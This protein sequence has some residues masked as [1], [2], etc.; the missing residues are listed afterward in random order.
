MSNY[1]PVGVTV[2]THNRTDLLAA[3]LESIVAQDY[4]GPVEIVVVHDKSTPAEFHEELYSRLGVRWVPNTCTSGLAGARN[5]GVAALPTDLVAFCDDDDTWHPSKLRNQIDEWNRSPEANLMAT[6]SEI[7][8]KGR[9]VPRLTPRRWITHKAL[10]RNRMATMAS[11]SFL[12][13]KEF[14]LSIG[15][16]GEGA[17]RGQ[18]EDWDL[19]LRASRHG[20]VLNVNVPLVRVMWDRDSYFTTH[21]ESKIAGLRWILDEHPDIWDDRVAL[22]RVLG[23][24]AYW[25]ASSSE[26]D[27][28]E[29]I[30]RTML[31]N[32]TQWRAF[33]ALLVEARVITS[34]QFLG[35]AAR[36]G[37]GM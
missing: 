20:P 37:R 19:L 24:I 35:A 14:L 2:P 21:Y 12:M 16:V 33:A 4:P 11:S 10:L 29:S 34:E 27:A 8:T 26:P 13:K 32:P 30:K 1:P 18:L 7:I 28:M 6:S 5:S 17:P 15:G 22:A 31:A 36:F 25:Q 3:T 23:K 9:A